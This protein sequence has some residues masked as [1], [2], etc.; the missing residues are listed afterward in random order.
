MYRT[1][2]SIACVA[3]GWPGERPPAERPPLSRGPPGRDRG[4]AL[5]AP[6]RKACPSDRVNRCSSGDSSTVSDEAWPL[7]PRE[8]TRGKK[9]NS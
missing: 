8:E 5:T 7:T 6:R 4:A 3:C 1:S 2:F 9:G